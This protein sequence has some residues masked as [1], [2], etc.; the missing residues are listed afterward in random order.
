MIIL[1][2]L[3]STNHKP[4][5]E[6]SYIPY[7]EQVRRRRKTNL[8]TAAGIGSSIAGGKIYYNIKNKRINKKVQDLK[9]KA[10]AEATR[11]LNEAPQRL[12]GEELRN[13]ENNLNLAVPEKMR[14]IEV[15]SFPIRSKAEKRAVLIGAT[16]LGLTLAA[17]KMMKERD[18]KR[19]YYESSK[20]D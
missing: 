12:S 10:V 18:K 8:L 2:K 16:G 14:E 15:S 6:K 20:K 1:R 9:D 7:E 17:R 4:E 3:Y 19:K 5:N 11:L 13:F